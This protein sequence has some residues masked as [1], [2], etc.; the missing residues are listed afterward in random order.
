[1][2]KQISII[3]PTYNMQKYLGKCLDSLLI[4]EIEEVE[5]LV[6]NDGSSDNS[7]NIALRYQEL[8]P[9]SIVVIN[10]EN[11][12]Y[13]SCINAALPKTTGRYIKILDADD[14]FDI[15]EFSKFVNLLHSVDDDVVISS[16]HT[17]NT[18]GEIIRSG[19]LS[20]YDIEENKTF[21]NYDIF[22]TVLRKYTA[23]HRIAYNKRVFSGIKYH[24]T[25][26]ISYTDIEWA[27]IPMSVCE[28]IRFTDIAVYRYLEGREGQT[29]S[30]DR[31]L[32]SLDH[33]FKV[34]YSL[35]R[36]IENVKQDIAKQY[37]LVH[38]VDF[39]RAFYNEILQNRTQESMKLLRN[40]DISLKHDYPIVY[41]MIDN[42]RYS[43]LSQFKMFKDLR[44][45]GYPINYKIPIIERLKI[46][47]RFRIKRFISSN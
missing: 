40:Y 5:I 20:Y 38:T 10:K 30:I 43:E 8:Y 42:I 27:T 45:K 23:M 4:P 13:G 46:A 36:E 2:K 12:N 29:V 19:N 18:E 11:G 33:L 17:V 24:Q 32:K 28:T 22:D 25:E 9:E 1:M 47:I 35:L 31:V 21:N 26:G 16:F 39:H 15:N 14:T 37:I 44:K 7:L 3:I 6:V 34:S 41:D